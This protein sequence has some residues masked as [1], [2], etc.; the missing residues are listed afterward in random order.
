MLLAQFTRAPEATAQRA[1]NGMT[2]ITP[3]YQLH[4]VPSSSRATGRYAGL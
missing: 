4:I 3:V 1:L 2:N